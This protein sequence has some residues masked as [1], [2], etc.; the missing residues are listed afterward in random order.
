MKNLR[1]VPQAFALLMAASAPAPALAADKLLGKFGRWEAHRSSANNETFC[2]AAS[3]PTKSDGKIAKRG[4]AALMISHWPK[5]KSFGQV[6][7]KIGYAMKKEAGVDLAIGK[8]SFKLVVNGD[9]AYGENE[10][11]DTAILAALK[12]A[13]N[14]TATSRPSEGSAKIVDTYAIDGLAKALAA[15]DKE[16]GAGRK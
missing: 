2:Y 12:G 6:Q 4:E 15:I 13:K 9:S 14:A 10:K 8:K 7:T 11:A 3:L 16:C 5:R 1:H